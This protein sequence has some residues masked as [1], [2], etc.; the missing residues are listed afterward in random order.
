[1]FEPADPVIYY[2]AVPDVRSEQGFVSA[3]PDLKLK[4]FSRKQRGSKPAIHVN[5]SIAAGIS[6]AH[7]MAADVAVS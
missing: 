3:L 1:M 4:V 7:Q 2:A 5:Y 6:K